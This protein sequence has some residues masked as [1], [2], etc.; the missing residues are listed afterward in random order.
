M[1]NLLLFLGV[2]FT[3]LFAS[4]QTPTDLFFSEYVEGSGNN[5]GVEIYNPTNQSIDLNNY[6]VARYS[7]GSADYTLGGIT[8]LS[9]I[10]EPY[11]TFV[12]VN[13]QITSTSTSPA[14]SPVLQALADQLPIRINA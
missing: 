14:C 2:L 10:L 13:G 3:T 7:N 8:H 11:K 9:G 6:W 5:K 1:K 4:A 12:L